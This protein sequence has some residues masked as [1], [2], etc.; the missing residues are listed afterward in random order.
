MEP[1]SLGPPRVAWRLPV[2]ARV[3]GELRPVPDRDPGHDH[4]PRRARDPDRGR[5]RRDHPGTPDCAVPH[6]C[7]T[8]APNNRKSKRRLPGI[9]PPTCNPGPDTAGASLPPAALVH[10][11]PARLRLQSKNVSRRGA[12]PPPAASLEAI[13]FSS[14]H[15]PFRRLEMH[16]LCQRTTHSKRS[17]CWILDWCLAAALVVMHRG[18]LAPAQNP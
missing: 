12:N 3:S 6:T 2:S 1:Q 14:L 7:Y 13:S 4:G 9:R 15:S 8:A 17:C 5:G 11:K 18:A 16:A 10:N